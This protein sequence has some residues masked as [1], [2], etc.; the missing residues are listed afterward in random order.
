VQRTDRVTLLA[1][2]FDMRV[3]I[4]GGRSFKFGGGV[5]EWGSR[6]GARSGVLGKAPGGRSWGE[7]LQK[8]TTLFVKVCHFVTI[9]LRCMHDY[10]NQ[11]NVK[12]KKINLDAEKW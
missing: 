2:L 12:W 4:G 11:F 9:L 8:L 5:Q 3:Y 1:P 7:T 10:T 6:G